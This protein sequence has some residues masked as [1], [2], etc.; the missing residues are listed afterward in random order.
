MRTTGDLI[1]MTVASTGKAGDP[2]M[3][4]LGYTAGFTEDGAR[5]KSPDGWYGAARSWGIDLSPGTDRADW[6]QGYQDACRDAQTA[7]N[8]WAG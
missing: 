8:G 4:E 3:Y 5:P 1:R 2:S 7:V 6:K